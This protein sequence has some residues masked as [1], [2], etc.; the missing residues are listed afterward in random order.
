MKKDIVSAGK[1]KIYTHINNVKAQPKSTS[2]DCV[3]GC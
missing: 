2:L 1:N 3:G